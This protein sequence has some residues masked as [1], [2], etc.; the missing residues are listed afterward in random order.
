VGQSVGSTAAHDLKNRNKRG[1]PAHKLLTMFEDYSNL[2][3]Q[4]KMKFHR[5][6]CD[7]VMLF[8]FNLTMWQDDRYVYLGDLELTN[9][10]YKIMES[11]LSSR[12]I[13]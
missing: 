4:F 6:F 10:T 13:M 1:S 5:A 3:F 11:I 9:F 8:K 7:A 2:F 12:V